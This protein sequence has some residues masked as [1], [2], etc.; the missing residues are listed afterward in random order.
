MQAYLQQQLNSLIKRQI[1]IIALA[2][3]TLIVISTG[4]TTQTSINNKPQPTATSQVS[5]ESVS[6]TLTIA[7]IP[8]K[9]DK[10][11]QEQLQTLTEYLTKTLKR[12]VSIQAIKDYN[13]TVDLLVEE[14]VQVAIVGPL[15]YIEAKQRNPQ[16]EPIVAPINKS[17]GRPWYKSAI[18]ANSASGIK[19]L[20]DLN[21]KRLGFVSKL[22]TSGY[23]FAVVHL[24]DLGFKFDTDFASVQFF[25]SQDN[26]LAALLEGKVD[27]IAINLEMYNLAKEAGQVSENYQA[28][29]ESE[30]IPEYPI[31]VS[32]KLPPQL[33][34][35]LKE[36]FLSAPIG[37]LSLTG[38]PS[39]GYTLV[40]ESDYHQIEQ[41]KKQLDEKLGK[42]K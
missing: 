24:L 41:V 6:S 22:S 42:T 26:T 12:P 4:C 32:Q 35:E 3:P 11:Q 9:N 14:K 38:V 27:A 31:V 17:T 23:M 20:N 18:I 10:Q 19:S 37:M 25:K 33:I 34:A 2:V 1:A 7:S 5:A 8:S 39:N 13:R 36:A 28:I 30:P 16:I 40:E 29:W 15:S 21:G